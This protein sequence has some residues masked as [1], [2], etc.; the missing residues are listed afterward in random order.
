V[1]PVLAVARF[2]QRRP[3]PPVP[4]LPLPIGTQGLLHKR[5]IRRGLAGRSVQFCS[6]PTIPYE[7]LV[8]SATAKAASAGGKASLRG[9]L[10]LIPR[11]FAIVGGLVPPTMTFACILVDGDA[12]S[13]FS[14]GGAFW[15]T[16]KPVQVGFEMQA[17]YLG[18]HLRLA[19]L[20]RSTGKRCCPEMAGSDWDT[21]A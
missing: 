5:Q 10:N 15:S 13:T 19:P 8:G 3:N 6:L 2:V 7:T 9:E 4:P 21:P 11:H 14:N 20:Q 17:G 18:G 1:N 16:C 12:G